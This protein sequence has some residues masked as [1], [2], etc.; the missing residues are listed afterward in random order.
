MG[1]AFQSPSIE[2][3]SSGEWCP[4]ARLFRNLLYYYK[5]YPSNQAALNWKIS[6]STLMPD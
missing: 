2:N 6:F 1:A 4:L 3:S 5:T